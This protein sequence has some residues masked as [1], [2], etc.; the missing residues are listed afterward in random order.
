MVLVYIHVKKIDLWLTARDRKSLRIVYFLL[1][2][3]LIYDTNTH[4]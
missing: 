3:D 1:L 4:Q 2:D